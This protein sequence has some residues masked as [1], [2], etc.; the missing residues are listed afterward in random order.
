MCKR[1]PWLLLALAGGLAGCGPAN[2]LTLG[3]VHGTITYK[4]Q[5]VRYGFVTFNPDFTKQTEG[6]AAMATIADDGSYTMSTEQT[7]DGAVVGI[8]K[9]GIT[10]LDPTP[11]KAE[12]VVDP[13]E[14]PKGYMASKASMASLP[15]KRKSTAD[16]TFTDKGGK[17][18]RIVTP[19]P[20]RNPE[21]SGI[22]V[23][24]GGGSNTVNIVIKENGSVEL[25]N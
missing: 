10:G 9:V 1:R 25:Q 5:P 19:L 8:H 3:K 22:T 24:V 4:G 12:A 7:G 11:V 17:T 14:N 23:K 16:T 2:G 18:Y 21:T 6:P 20:L 15:T 13:Q